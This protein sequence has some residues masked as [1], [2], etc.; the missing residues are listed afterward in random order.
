MSK[1]GSSENRGIDDRPSE[2]AYQNAAPRKIISYSRLYSNSNVVDALAYGKPVVFG[3]DVFDKFMDLSPGNATLTFPTKDET[4][5]GGHAMCIVGYNLKS[6]VFLAKNSFGSQWGDN[7]YCWIPFDY[8]ETY[9][10]DK[11]IFTIPN[12][13]LI[14]G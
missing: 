10:Y 2:E 8:F 1:N 3:I 7:G 14:K 9:S 6:R 11:W 4:L 12:L 13:T 5:V